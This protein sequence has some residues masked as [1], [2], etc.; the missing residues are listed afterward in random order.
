M[1]E[2][3]PGYSI[4]RLREV[5][6]MISEWRRPLLLT[7]ARADGDAVGCIV[8][9]LSILRSI[10]SRPIA[11]L[12]EPP[13]ERYA[14]LTENE[15]IGIWPAGDGRAG[16]AELSSAD[17]VLVMDTCAYSQ[18]EP[19]ADWLRA[20][21]SEGTRR[22]L[23]IDHH[24]TRDD[25]ADEYLIDESAGAACL[26]LFELAG[27]CGWDLDQ[28]AIQGLFVGIA[29]DTGWFRFSNTDARVLHSAAELVR[30]GAAPDRAYGLLYESEPARRVGL[31][32]AALD[33][34]ELFDDGR[35]AVLSLTKAMFERTGATPADT[36]DLVNEPMRIRTVEVSVLL[37]EPLDG[38]PAPIKVSLRSRG[39]V[40]VAAV[41]ARLHGGG[42]QRAAGAK[43]AGTLAAV[44]ERILAELMKKVR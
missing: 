22:V 29:T 38:P 33:A 16:A 27:A 11:L 6:A 5:G 30:R 32:R 39:A 44:K 24:V 19:A 20:V 10:D 1:G 25:L 8:A 9:M 28:A 3:T 13:T 15:G 40:D 43:V 14:W 41:A 31:F 18:L 34:L 36:E 2:E 12:F 35:V 4:E 42:H 26:I 21:R 17:G 23:A 7:H 37:A